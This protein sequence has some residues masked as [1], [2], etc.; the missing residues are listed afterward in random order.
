M[1]LLRTKKH[2]NTEGVFFNSKF[3]SKYFK[4]ATK[5]L[6]RIGCS[7]GLIVLLTAAFLPINVTEKQAIE[8]AEQFIKDNGYTLAPADTTKLHFELFDHR[9]KSLDDI[10]KMRHNLLN[11]KAFCI[12]D[13]RD[14]WDVGFLSSY[15]KMNE[16]DSAQ[17]QTDLSGIAVIVAKDGNGIRMAHKQPLFSYFKKL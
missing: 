15:I 9:E 12:S 13:G 14:D 2:Q 16:L 10:L 11:P 17:K 5:F 3:I 7:I 6:T 4:M 1:L 8:R